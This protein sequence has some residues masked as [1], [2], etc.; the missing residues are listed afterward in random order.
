MQIV[1]Y[2]A[3]VSFII[4]CI[5]KIIKYACLPVHL[6]WELYPV[7][8]EATGSYG[9]SYFENI[10]WWEKPRDKTFMGEIK[11][12]IKEIFL[13]TLYYKRNKKYWYLVFP[14]HIGGYL[15]ILWFIL[16]LIGAILLH[17]GHTIVPPVNPGD[18]LLYYITLITGVCGLVIT[19]LSCVGL[20]VYKTFNG[21]MKMYAVPLDYLNLLM[22]LIIMLAGLGAWIFF[23]SDFSMMREIIRGTITYSPIANVSGVTYAFVS[24]ICLFLLYMPLTRMMHFLAKYFTYHKVLWDDEPNHVVNRM[25]AA[26]RADAEKPISWS[27]D[28]ICEYKTWSEIS[29]TPGNHR[30][31]EIR[32]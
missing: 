9:S 22:I 25:T 11:F 4:Q 30:N 8:H 24:L 1:I 2:I 21:S 26:L 32:K 10:D 27:S 18:A 7:A 20:I 5:L 16:L 14:F 28:H 17:Y 23:D 19:F 13:F 29:G 31:G 12:M 3:L 6:R 15:L